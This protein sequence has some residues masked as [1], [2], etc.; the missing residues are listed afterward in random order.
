MNRYVNRIIIGLVLL[1][2]S[3][4]TIEHSFP[5]SQK[6][7]GGNLVIQLK[8][9]FDGKPFLLDRRDFV[10]P[11][12]DTV[13]FDQLRFYLGDFA[14]SGTDEKTRSKK[15]YVLVDAADS[16]SWSIHFN[17]L[18]AGDFNQVDFNIGVDSLT[19]ISNN[20]Y[21]A[22]DPIHGM[23]WAWNSGYIDAKLQGKSAACNTLHH[24]FEFHIGGYQAPFNACRRI[25]L[26]VKNL[27]IT[28]NQT[29]TLQIVADVSA[30][31]NTPN[32]IDLSKMN[33]IVLPGK[34]AMMM[35]D[36]YRNMFSVD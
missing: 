1:L 15:G 22:L 26:P 13:E 30:W 28:A 7:P 11:H 35:A 32:R 6:H 29:S 18:E 20:M 17:Q 3:S 33:E 25:S 4:F 19:Q 2:T 9:T 10:T 31:F 12:G 24:A 27:Q 23:Y 16:R 21:D 8:L 14:F 36:N 34:E 5:V